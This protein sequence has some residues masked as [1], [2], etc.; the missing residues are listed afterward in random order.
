MLSPLRR[1]GRRWPCAVAVWL[2]AASASCKNDAADPPAG[3]QTPNLRTADP[4]MAVE[5]VPVPAGQPDQVNPEEDGP[6]HSV[7]EDMGLTEM[8]LAEMGLGGL[9]SID[10]NPLGGCVS[11]HVD[12]EDE[13]KKGKHLAEEVGCIECHGPSDGH[14]RD[15][16][17]EIK[18]D[19][20]FARKD[21]DRLCGECHKCSRPGA[22]E[23]P[24][25]HKVCTDCHRPHSL[26]PV[27]DAEQ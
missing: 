12:V 9:E 22:E 25:E 10:A 17:N 8:E 6:A 4:A 2:L 16:N 21:V 7:L 11:C 15:E 23:P 27:G 20:V 14:V 3:P 5:P 13:L 26:A 24:E 1:P 19:Q 18:P